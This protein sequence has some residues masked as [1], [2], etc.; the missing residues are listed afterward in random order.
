MAFL[1]QKDWILVAEAFSRVGSIGATKTLLR[2][3]AG[4]Y[5]SHFLPVVW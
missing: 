2:Q 4:W 5:Q 3:L 1:D